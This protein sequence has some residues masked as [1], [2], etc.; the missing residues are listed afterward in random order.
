MHRLAVSAVR[1]S[2]VSYDSRFSLL[3]SG[4]APRRNPETGAVTMAEGFLADF[5]EPSVLPG[6]V[7]A[8]DDVFLADLDWQQVST[9][10]QWSVSSV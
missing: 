8:A 2:W 7:S 4:R 1:P 9:L 3:S 5:V 6:G 10:R